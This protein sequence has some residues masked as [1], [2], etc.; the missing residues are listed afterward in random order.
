ML[1][2][3][4]LLVHFLLQYTCTGGGWT[5]TTDVT[6][7]SQSICRYKP[8]TKVECSVRAINNVSGDIGKGD[9]VI[10]TLCKGEYDIFQISY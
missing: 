7:L 9:N 5:T 4:K 3:L 6:I 2:N 10:Y 1:A 8:Y